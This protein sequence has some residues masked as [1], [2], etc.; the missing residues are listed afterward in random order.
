MTVAEEIRDKTEGGKIF[1]VKFVK[2]NGEVRD[3]VCRLGVK[4][5][6]KG[7]GMAYDPKDYNLLTVCDLQAA[8][9][10]GDLGFRNISLDNILE[11]KISGTR[12]DL[13]EGSLRQLES[14]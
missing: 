6:V 5:G 8:K 10:E 13:F 2:K 4:R 12:Y 7:V 14:E 11:I 3:M 9:Q 1:S